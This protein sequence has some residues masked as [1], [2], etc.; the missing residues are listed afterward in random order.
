MSPSSTCTYI[1]SSGEYPAAAAMAMTLAQARSA[2]SANVRR[3]LPVRVER[4]HPAD[5]QDAVLLAGQAER[6]ACREPGTGTD[7]LDRH[8]CLSL[9]TA[10]GPREPVRRCSG[11]PAAA[12][13]PRLACRV[14]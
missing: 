12:R 11:G 10:G 13:P 9:R 6:E 7:P 4:G 1:R 8:S 14:R 2:S 5:V 3:E